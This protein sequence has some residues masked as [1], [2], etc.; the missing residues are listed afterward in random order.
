MEP[1]DEALSLAEPLSL[2]DLPL[3]FLAQLVRE[4]PSASVLPL[5]RTCRVFRDLVC[6]SYACHLEIALPASDPVDS[7]RLLTACRRCKDVQCRFRDSKLWPSPAKT[8]SCR[9]A[10][11]TTAR[12][13]QCG[14]SHAS[15]RHSQRTPQPPSHQPSPAATPGDAQP[16]LADGDVSA[17]LC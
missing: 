16:E 4:A 2:A 10:T 14:P 17:G 13:L 7:L 1:S 5:F 3:S 11:A 12:T 9:W 15:A 6:A 8:A